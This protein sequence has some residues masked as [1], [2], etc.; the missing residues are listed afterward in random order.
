MTLCYGCVMTTNRGT[1]RRSLRVADSLWERFAAWCNGRGVS[2]TERLIEH[3]KEDLAQG[4]H[5]ER[6]KG[7]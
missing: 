1:T 4:E 7:A 2:M 5:S 3:I 6:S